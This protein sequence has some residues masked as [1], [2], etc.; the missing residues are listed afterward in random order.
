M[1]AHVLPS[2]LAEIDRLAGDGPRG[3]VVDEAMGSLVEV[4][5]RE[6]DDDG[7]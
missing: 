5:R 1:V 7:P 6:V 4:E 3:P 2:T